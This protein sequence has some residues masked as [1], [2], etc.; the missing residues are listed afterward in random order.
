MTLPLSAPSL[1]S[2][3]LVIWTFCLTLAFLL[4]LPVDIPA[5]SPLGCYC[6]AF[7]VTGAGVAQLVEL[8][9]CLEQHKWMFQYSEDMLNKVN[10]NKF[11]HITVANKKMK[12]RIIAK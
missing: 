1:V 10:C 9:G 3:T 2:W 8:Y 12:G 5:W 6:A 11:S 7:L 4:A